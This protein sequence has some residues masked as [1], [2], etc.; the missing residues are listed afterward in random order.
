MCLFTASKPRAFRHGHKKTPCRKSRQGVHLSG[1]QGRNRT[2]DTRIFSPL[3]YQL[4]YLA[5]N[6]GGTVQK[7][8]AFNQFAPPAS[9]RSSRRRHITL[10]R[11]CPLAEEKLLHLLLQ[12]LTRLWFKWR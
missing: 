6:L 9:R 8:R 12:K 7:R 11:R 1:G 2:N 5:E 3:L 4:S 10:G